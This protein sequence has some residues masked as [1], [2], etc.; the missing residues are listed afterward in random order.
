MLVPPGIITM[1]KY[2]PLYARWKSLDGQNAVQFNIESGEIQTVFGN[3]RGI[4]LSG[5]LPGGGQS[6]PPGHV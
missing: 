2:V 6:P 3:N 5:L 4:F 1:K